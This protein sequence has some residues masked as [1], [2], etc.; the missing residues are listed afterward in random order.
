MILANKCDLINSLTS[1]QLLAA[2]NLHSIRDRP[3]KII[4]CSGMRGDGLQVWTFDTLIGLTHTAYQSELSFEACH[5]YSNLCL[6]TTKKK[7]FLWLMVKSYCFDQLLCK[8]FRKIFVNQ[9]FI[10]SHIR[11]DFS[12]YLIKLNIKKCLPKESYRTGGLVRV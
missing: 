2:L 9:S 1:D 4:L 7:Y 3:W 5:L 6:S 8:K 12:L 11:W 10:M